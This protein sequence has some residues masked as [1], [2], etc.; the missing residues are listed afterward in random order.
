MLGINYSQQFDK[1][2]PNLLNVTVAL[3]WLPM[4]IKAKL[5]HPIY[6]FFSPLYVFCFK[7]LTLFVGSK[8]SSLKLNNE[9]MYAQKELS[10]NWF[11]EKMTSVGA[12]Y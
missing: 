3:E 7:E 5:L 9:K 10:I 1:I 2:N 11:Q 4:M 6:G 12:Q 8:I